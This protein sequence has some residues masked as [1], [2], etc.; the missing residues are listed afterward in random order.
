MTHELTCEDV[1]CR[2][3]EDADVRRH[4]NEC[5]RST[6]GRCPEHSIGITHV[7]GESFPPIVGQST[8]SITMPPLTGWQC[9]CCRRCYGPTVYSCGRCGPFTCPLGLCRQEG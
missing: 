2:C 1:G 7:A 6:A 5:A 9:P 3:V 8:V 4:C